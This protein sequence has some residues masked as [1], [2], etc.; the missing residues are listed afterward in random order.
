MKF[1]KYIK[2]IRLLIYF[3]FCLMVIKKYLL[4]KIKKKKNL[5]KYEKED[6]LASNYK[7]FLNNNIK[8]YK[9]DN[10]YFNLIDVKYYYS[11]KFKLIKIKYKMGFFDKNN[12]LILPSDLTLYNN[13][14]IICHIIII[15]NNIEINSI[16]NI[17]LNNYYECIEFFNLNEQFKVGIKI[18]I[19]NK[20][21]IEGFSYF[22]SE[23]I[24]KRVIYKNDEI[25]E[26]ML[27]N[28]E[29]INIYN[30]INNINLNISLKLK[31]SYMNY[32][33]LSLKRNVAIFENIWY[34]K[35]IYNEYFCFC[36]G[37]YCLTKDNYQRCKYYSYLKI[38][39]DNKNIYK[40]TDFF[41]IDFIFS[42]YS[43]DDVY[44]IFREMETQ[45]K[46]VHYLTENFDIYQKH[47]FKKEKCLN[48]IY[49]NKNNYTLNGDFL[50]NYLTLLLKLKQV[51]SS[52]GIYF[53]YINNLF[54]NIEYITYICVGHGVSFFK[55][56]LYARYSWYGQ[57]VY[58]KILI[59]PS[60]KLISVAKNYGWN[61][62][63]IIK[64][65]LP[66]WDKYNHQNL[67]LLKES[68][69]IN[70]N[71]IFFMFT[72]RRFN[73]NNNLS[74][75]YFKN[76]FNL[77]NNKNLNLA[78][79]KNNLILYFTLHH[80]LKH[81][82]KKF[83]NIKYIQLIKECS[84][85]E[86]LSKTNLVVTDFSSIIFDIMYR[87]KPFVIYIPDANDPKI[88]KIYEKSY[89]ELIQSLKND[90]I[91][92]ENK[93][94]ELNET[95]DKI[96]YYINNNFNLESKLTKFYDSFGLKR[97]DNINEFINYITTF[98]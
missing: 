62:K 27:F 41:F 31:K 58:D 9:N 4:K 63:N 57:K 88:E 34:F 93:Y 90:T 5:I 22:I 2:I 97:G 91:I 78:L 3:L 17:Y 24:L 21:K 55:H 26:F 82:E 73:K 85:S 12:H 39:D 66:R 11:L 40:K 23:T 32:P 42:E 43:S 89:F 30:K 86:C 1:N 74:N 61:D 84:I 81:Y 38:I 77:I 75:Y 56:F 8:D 95:V 70:N 92:F 96:I 59:P 18:Y 68:S 15:N 46:P 54:Y 83:T 52:G 64:I 60:N 7:Y 94:F 79:K 28:K 71:S 36:K 50:E 49:V 37:L 67:S 45:K 51:I 29:Y 65:N 48:I 69:E 47:C 13:L 44:P 10:L 80:R 76:I 16:P 25:F 35:N 87:R 20:N 98:N 19:S 6:N 33:L 14:H 53:N 72:W